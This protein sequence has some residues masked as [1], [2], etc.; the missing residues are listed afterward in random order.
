MKNELVPRNRI[1]YALVLSL[2]VAD[3]LVF[4]SDHTSTVLEQVMIAHRVWNDVSS[5]H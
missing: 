4:Q 1:Y 3:L 5:Q 2:F